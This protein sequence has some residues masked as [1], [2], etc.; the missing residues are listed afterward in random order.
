METVA[1]LC[2]SL[3][4]TVKELEKETTPGLMICRHTEVCWEGN[5]D[6]KWP[7][8]PDSSIGTCGEEVCTRMG[9]V[10]GCLPVEEA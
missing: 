4:I 6:H 3:G 9:V 5:C 1:D 10:A 2:K 8:Y 7:H